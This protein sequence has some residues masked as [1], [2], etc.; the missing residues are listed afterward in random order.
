MD[1]K[2][3]ASRSRNPVPVDWDAVRRRLE[4]AR[5]AIERNWMPD[6]AETMRILDARALELAQKPVELEAP[7]E[8]VE[9]VEFLLSGERYV[10]ESQFVR[11]VCPLESF[12]PVPCAPSFVLGIFNLRGEILSVIDLRKFFGL[13]ESGLPDLNKIIVLHSGNMAFGILA[14]AIAGVGR[15]LVADIQPSLP[16]ITGIREKYLKGI[17]PEQAVFLDAEKILSDQELVVDERVP[18]Y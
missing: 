13:A 5:D 11:D 6:E 14:D 16:T 15:V 10:I 18:G 8:R 17:T 7:G 2:R 1:S 12:S 3:P 4:A 9:V